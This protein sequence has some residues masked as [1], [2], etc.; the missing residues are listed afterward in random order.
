[1]LNDVTIPAAFALHLVLMT[2]LLL[3]TEPGADDITVIAMY[4]G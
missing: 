4:L 2:S 3:S 1:M